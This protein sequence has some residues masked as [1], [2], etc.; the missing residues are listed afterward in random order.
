MVARRGRVLLIAQQ[1]VQRRGVA[2]GQRHFHVQ[3][4]GGIRLRH[5]MHAG[6]LGRMVAHQRDRWFRGSL[7]P[8]MADRE[9]NDERSHKTANGATREAPGGPIACPSTNQG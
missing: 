3:L 1:L 9:Q 2:Q 5:R 7:G 4:G 6:G 8:C